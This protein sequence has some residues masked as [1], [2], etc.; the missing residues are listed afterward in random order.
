MIAGLTV[1]AILWKYPIGRIT[2]EMR[3]G[4]AR[5]L[6]PA[7]FGALGVI[8]LTSSTSDYLVFRSII[9]DLKF[10]PLMR[11]KAGVSILNALGPALNY[12]GHALWIHRRFGARPAAAA[13]ALMYIGLGDLVAVMAWVTAAIW[14]GTDVPAA[15][16]DGLGIGAPIVLVVALVLHMWPLR[17]ERPIL[18]P[19]RG[20][21]IATRLAILGV[22]CTTIAIIV[23]GTWIAAN[24]FG[25]PIPFGAA[26]TWVPILLVVAAMPVNIAGLGPVQVAWLAVFAPWAAPTQIL[27]FQ[28]L[29]HASMLAALLVR[30]GPFLRAV[31]AD[32]TR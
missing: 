15:T 13:G 10:W 29:W 21:A 4:D 23:T 1:A 19:W 11:G 28:F 12:G 24:G 18:T 9:P 16:R 8:W 30:G 17:S 3:R 27:A 14:L 26:A 32:I 20:L 6:L 25:I 31:V 22:R 7:A 5:A 2:E